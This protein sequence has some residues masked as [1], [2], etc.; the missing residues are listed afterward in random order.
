MHNGNFWLGS[1][2]IVVFIIGKDLY[3]CG[4][5]RSFYPSAAL[6]IQEVGIY[7]VT[8]AAIVSPLPFLPFSPL[9]IYL[10]DMQAESCPERPTFPGLELQYKR[11]VGYQPFS[12]DSR[13][14]SNISSW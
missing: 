6:I 7:P 10:L 2:L 14:F 5:Q 4:F 8:Y 13:S 11:E 12:C 3:I 1:L 9:K